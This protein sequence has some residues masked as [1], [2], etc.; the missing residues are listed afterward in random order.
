[1]AIEIRVVSGYEDVQRWAR[2][3]NQQG[4]DVFTPEM[5][6]FVRASEPE[7]I[8]LLA[9][10]D[11]KAV[12][13]AVLSGDPRSVE[14]RVPWIDIN[15]PLEQRGRGI[16]SALLQEVCAH[17]RRLGYIGLRCTL[18]GDDEKSRAYLERR[19]FVVRVRTRELA[20]SL[21]SDPP[22]PPAPPEGV[23]LEWLVDRPEVLEA[24]YV[25]AC[26]AASLR[27]DFVA[28]FVRTESEWRMYEL[29]T[30]LVRLDLTV[31]ALAGDEV[32]GYAVGEDSLDR[33]ALVHRGVVAGAE[34]QD[35]GLLETLVR[36]QAEA[37]HKAGLRELRAVPWLV[38]LERMY[39]GLGYTPGQTWL[40]L[41]G[42]LLG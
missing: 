18:R 22:A 3:R 37:A 11:G 7:H 21:G 31:V 35:R 38:S 24:M 5:T 14:S 4:P 28:R 29:G 42:P 2:A 36:A 30:P 41:E 39:A 20:L 12:G 23:Q 19:G 26:E 13:T 32:V 34:W 6:A 15:V 16:G 33:D 8:D 10:E 40:E 17:A 1:V 27:P 25:F 9:L